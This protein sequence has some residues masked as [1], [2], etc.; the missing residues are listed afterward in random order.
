MQPTTRHAT[1]VCGV[2][3]SPHA[4]DVVDFARA[5]AE[6]LQLRLCLVHSVHPDG[7]LAGEPGIDALRRG[8]DLLD[9]LAPRTIASSRSASQLELFSGC[10]RAR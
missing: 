10:A 2:D 8:D 3:H 4:T 1:L 9:G 6:R 5:L 7:F